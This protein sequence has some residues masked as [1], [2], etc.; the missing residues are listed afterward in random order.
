MEKIGFTVFGG[1]GFIGTELS[2]YLRDIEIPVWTPGRVEISRGDVFRR[3]LHHV[4][5]AI[6]MTADFRSR[7][8]D[9]IDAH[10]SL[11]TK[12]LHE[13]RWSSWLFLSSTRV[14]GT[15][16]RD[17]KCSED[18]P[19]TLVPDANS[20]YDLSKLLGEAMC[21][22]RTEATCR[23]ARLSNVI[24]PNMG[25]KNFL[26]SIIDDAARSKSV[27]IGEGPSSRKDYIPVGDVARLIYSIATVGKSRKYNVASGLGIEHARLATLLEE[28]TGTNLVFKN[29]AATRRFPEI[30]TSK[31][32]EEFEYQRSDIQSVIQQVANQSRGR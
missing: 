11:L 12:L 15:A 3:D 27:V 24:G 9:T 16:E 19:I 17:K 6:G 32:E 23:I 22:S 7:L 1:G 4:V 29:N 26:G 18:D 2:A 20:V 13:C 21:L 14:Y 8:G 30:D 10:V 28:A 5:Y 31:I 25:P